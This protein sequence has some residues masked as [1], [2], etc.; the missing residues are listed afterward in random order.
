MYS[1][2]CESK[3]QLS[4]ALN[5]DHKK[6]S[7]NSSRWSGFWAIIL[8][9]SLY[10]I[11][12]GHD[13]NPLAYEQDGSSATPSKNGILFVTIISAGNS[14]PKTKFRFHRGKNHAW[15]YTMTKSCCEVV[16]LPDVG[17]ELERLWGGKVKDEQ[18]CMG[19]AQPTQPKTFPFCRKEETA[20][21]TIIN[22]GS[23]KREKCL[24]GQCHEIF[25][26]WFFSSIS[27]PPAPEYPPAPLGPFQIFVE[28]S[29]RYSQ[30]KVDHRC[31]WHRWQMRK[32]FN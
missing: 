23:C 7:W 32:I 19:A 31:R 22:I 1:L 25:R 13:A 18:V 11:L 17:D 8:V 4:H 24:K 16:W 12:K 26:I 5:L 10:K 2:L 29:R 30:L 27:F 15:Y 21:L 9:F 20:F 14:Q 6:I 28:N 3:V